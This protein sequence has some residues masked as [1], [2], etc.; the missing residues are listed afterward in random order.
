MNRYVDIYLNV[1]W[2]TN[3]RQNYLDEEVLKPYL[4]SITDKEL[5]LFLSKIYLIMKK[6]WDRLN[7]L[8]DKKIDGSGLAVFRVLYSIVLL[9]EIS[10]LFYFRHLIF[11]EIPFINEAEINF[12]VPLALWAFIVVLLLFGVFTKF[13]TIL[14]YLFGLVLIGTIDTFEYHVY[15]AYM[16][17]NFMLMFMPIS[18]VWS[19]DKLLLK[20]KYTSAKFTYNPTNKVAQLF[21]FILLFFGIAFVYFDSIFFK[22][23]SENWTSGLGMWI[24]ANLPMISH[25]ELSFID[26]SEFISKTLGYTTLVFELVFIFFFWKKSFRWPFVII[27]LGLHIGIL[28]EFPIP[29]FALAVSGLYM[30]L[31]PVSFWSRILGKRNGR[32]EEELTFYYDGE[33]PLC[34]KTKVFIK[35]FDFYNRIAFKTVQFDSINTP[36]LIEI[37]EHEL[38]DNVYS[39]DYYGN[40]YSGLDTYKQVLKRLPVFYVLWLLSKLPFVQF[41]GE[42]IYRF[43]ADNRNTERCTDQSCGIEIVTTPEKRDNVK[44]LRNLTMRDLKKYSI[45]SVFIMLFSVQSLITIS[46]IC[47]RFPVINEFTV[48]RYYLK[49]ISLISNKSRELFGVTKHGVFMDSHFN[50]YNHILSIYYINDK[51]EEIRLPII[52]TDGSPDWYI[53]GG[54]WIKWTFRTMSPNV[55]MEHLQDGIMDFTAFWAHK[56]NISLED[57]VFMLKVKRID[58]CK[59]WKLDFNKNQSNKPWID[60]GHVQWIN[61]KY[62]PFI[63]KIESL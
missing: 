43:I 15:Y 4:K 45:L 53:Y 42:R 24:P 26:N 39:L 59:E 28:I 38:L 46:T 12:G 47:G 31:V 2:L 29:W 41:V 17:I 57:A 44:V 25:F 5:V 56:N 8:F 3:S 22:V 32:K 20:L 58:S 14:N 1:Y 19:L 48:T 52:K 30:T 13:T 21:Y 61:N 11:D 49:G 18:K 6:I 51:N 27:G 37:E 36:A 10:Y 33:C 62:I 63:K 54:N 34:A 55:N 16:S 50:D 7:R 40:V 35:H 9:C 60:A 23:T